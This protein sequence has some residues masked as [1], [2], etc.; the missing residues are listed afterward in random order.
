[1]R[2]SVERQSIYWS[3]YLGDLQQRKVGRRSSATVCLSLSPATHIASTMLL[4]ACHAVY[5]E[6]RINLFTRRGAH[7]SRMAS[8]QDTVKEKLNAQCVES[9]IRPKP[10][11]MLPRKQPSPLGMYRPRMSCTR[12]YCCT[13]VK[14]YPPHP[15]CAEGSPV[16]TNKAQI[17]TTTVSSG[18]RLVSRVC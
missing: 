5:S 18:R 16:E 3:I 8:R 7:H 17:V 13:T 10:L 14:H 12:S 6:S 15:K 9:S 4:A 11:T 1:M 2:G